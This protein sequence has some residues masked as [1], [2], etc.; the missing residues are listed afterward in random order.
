M[1]GQNEGRTITK[2]C[3]NLIAQAQA[4]EREADRMN[5]TSEA[6]KIREEAAKLWN[7]NAPRDSELAAA[8]KAVATASEELKRAANANEDTTAAQHAWNSALAHSR[9]LNERRKQADEDYERAEQRAKTKLAKLKGK[10]GGDLK[11]G[12]DDYSTPGD[13]RAKSTPQRKSTLSSSTPAKSAAGATIPRTTAS[14]APSAA[15]TSTSNEALSE[16]VARLHP[17]QQQ[18]P[19]QQ[20]PAQGAPPAQPAATLAA[21]NTAAS[22]RPDSRNSAADAI[23][24]SDVP[25]IPIAVGVNPS[26][27]TTSPAAAASTAQ[28]TPATSGTSAKDLHTDANVT[29]RAGGPHTVTS[30]ATAMSNTKGMLGAQSQTATQNGA[31]PHPVAGPLGVGGGGAP[32]SKRDSKITTAHSTLEYE[33]GVVPGGTIAQ[34]RPDGDDE[35]GDKKK[36]RAS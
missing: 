19:I 1:A 31:A 29:G 17:K 35:E 30:G 18:A 7:R 26:P 21:P 3:E 34:N 8:S 27:T 28:H 14:S 33:P 32:T 5:Q 9:E 23:K 6:L 16:L 10:G 24:S 13:G 11:G 25:D 12:A 15:A 2:A 4:N 20:A 22:T 36:R